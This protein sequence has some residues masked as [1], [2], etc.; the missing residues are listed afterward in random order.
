MPLDLKPSSVLTSLSKATCRFNP[1]LTIF[2]EN[3]EK[4]GD[5]GL[6]IGKIV[7]KI[8]RGTG[9]KHL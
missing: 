5:F 7:N 9:K 8:N 6:C 2:M 4:K 1:S 3:K